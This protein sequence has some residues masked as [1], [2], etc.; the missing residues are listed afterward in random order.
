MVREVVADR[1]GR[2]ALLEVLDSQS[3]TAG[4]NRTYSVTWSVTEHARSVHTSYRVSVGVFSVGGGMFNN[5]RNAAG[6]IVV[7]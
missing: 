1:N 2:I 4:Q 6:T 7:T 3:F 5:W